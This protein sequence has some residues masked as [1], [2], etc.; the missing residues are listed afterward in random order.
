[1]K[2]VSNNII[3]RFCV[4]SMFLAGCSLN[5]DKSQSE[6]GNIPETTRKILIVNHRG[7]NRLAPE[8]TYASAQKAIES[9]AAYVEVDV[10]RSKDGVYYLLHDK[11]LERTTNGSGLI[12]ETDSKVIDT[13]D[14]GNWFAHQYK[15]E[16]LPRLSDYLKWIKGKTKVYFDVKDADLNELL[17]IVHDAGMAQDCFFWFSDWNKA[18]KFRLLAPELALKVNAYSIE[19]IDTL[20]EIYN[21]QI[22]E[23]SVSYLS[24]EFINYCHGKGLKVMPWIAGDDWKGYRMAMRQNIDMINL[25]NPDV[26]SNMV[27]NGGVFKG[28]KLIA[29]RGGIVED[30]YN[31]YDPASIQSAIDQG[32]YMLEV[33]VQETKD[34]VLVVNH[35]NTYSRFYNDPRQITDMTWVEIQKLRPANGKDYRPISFEELA[36]ICT[37][38]IQ[39]MIDVKRNPSSEFYLKLGDILRKYNLLSGAYF[40]D[41]DARKYFWGEAKFM[42]RVNEINEIKEKFWKGEDVA[43]HYFLFD[44]GTR[45]TSTFV[46]MS[47]MAHITVVPT[48]NF[49]HYH[50][51]DA[52]RGAHRDIEFMK[53]CGITEFQIDSDF[54]DWLPTQ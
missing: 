2:T 37:G 41:Y 54:D 45:L 28:Y 25:D 49:G 11:A 32:Y 19:A 9:G 38:K 53:E 43:C 50:Y 31:E 17:D 6:N 20:V 10:R 46:K 48:V 42:I 47:Q 51:E 8:N 44:A 29:H 5:C 7:A 26:F 22:I 15:G 27:K 14:A 18:K 36:K 1:M 16:K 33:D 13:L 12:A 35:D 40:I 21:P 4:W 24:D 52:V 34:G 23:T 3:I 39:L 30:K